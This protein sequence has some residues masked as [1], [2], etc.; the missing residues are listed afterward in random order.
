MVPTSVDRRP[1]PPIVVA[2]IVLLSD[3]VDSH[4]PVLFIVDDALVHEAPIVVEATVLRVGCVLL[5]QEIFP[6]LVAAA[7]IVKFADHVVRFH[8]LS[9]NVMAV[10]LFGICVELSWGK[11]RAVVIFHGCSVALPER[12][13]V[14]VLR[15]HVVFCQVLSLVVIVAV[16]FDGIVPLPDE[17]PIVVTAIV[18]FDSI[19]VVFPKPS[20]WDTSCE[21]AVVTLSHAG[22]E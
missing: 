4:G 5:P 18:L 11:L 7:D 12:K 21:N 16:T 19:V 1:L 10:A 15:G 22:N 20:A 2:E 8:R 6:A 9:T 17:F 3:N 14:V 13:A